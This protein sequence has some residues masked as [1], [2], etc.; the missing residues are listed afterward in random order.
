ME[1]GGVDFFWIL[2]ICLLVPVYIEFLLQWRWV[3]WYFQSGPRV[4]SKS[5]PGSFSSALNLDIAELNGRFDD[6]WTKPTLFHQLTP[7]EVAFRDSNGPN[8]FRFN[9]RASIMHGLV[10]RDPYSGTI[11]VEGRLNW[12]AMGV[13]LFMVAIL[14]LMIVMPENTP[15]AVWFGVMF[16]IVVILIVVARM[17]F[18]RTTRRYDDIAYAVEKM[19]S[20]QSGR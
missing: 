13:L 4:Y 19:L 14:A 2:L 11:A 16:L 1:R 5:L 10:R 15:P 7:E 3:R 6:G 18:R 8:W 12:S 20:E 9:R 17:L